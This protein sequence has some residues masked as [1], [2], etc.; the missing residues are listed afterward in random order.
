[1]KKSALLIAAALIVLC[2]PACAGYGDFSARKDAGT[3]A[4]R[5]DG[6]YV[7]TGNAFYF[8]PPGIGYNAIMPV[9]LR[10]GQVFSFDNGA[11]RI[12]TDLTYDWDYYSSRECT[13]ESHT[14]GAAVS[15][16]LFETN[17]SCRPFLY[18]GINKGFPL[19]DSTQP[20]HIRNFGGLDFGIGFTSI[21][22]KRFSLVL[23][24]QW[25]YRISSYVFR[26]GEDEVWPLDA[27]Q[28]FSGGILLWGFAFEF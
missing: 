13:L 24:F 28:D 17:L 10:A 1:M 19:N 18:F 14:L 4:G 16:H 15:Y 5:G 22:G 26:P 7:I 21:P 27:R 6:K 20:E 3:L 9:Y 2:V 25:I 8:P 12:E 23:Q 11:T